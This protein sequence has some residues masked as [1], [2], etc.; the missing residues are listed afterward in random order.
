MQRSLKALT[1]NIFYQPVKNKDE[2]THLGEPIPVNMS[3]YQSSD[4]MDFYD[5]WK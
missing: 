2:Y 5:L 1:A 4:S 3:S